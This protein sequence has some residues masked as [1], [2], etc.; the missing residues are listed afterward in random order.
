M[1][2]YATSFFVNV[3]VACGTECGTKNPATNPRTKTGGS[4]ELANK[5]QKDYRIRNGKPY[6]RITYYD[7]QGRRRDVMRLAE[8]RAHAKELAAQMRRELKDHGERIVDADKLKFEE[9][10]SYYEADK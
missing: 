10:A 2:H 3:T 9:L 5:R 4:Q 8:S 7:E 1:L 6:A